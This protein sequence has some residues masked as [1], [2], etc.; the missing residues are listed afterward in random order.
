M[1][2]SSH[3]QHSS[4]GETPAPAATTA[5]AGQHVAGLWGRRG[6]DSS[7]AH[8]QHRPCE[9]GRN[10]LEPLSLES[11]VFTRV[12]PFKNKGLLFRNDVYIFWRRQFILNWKE[13]H[14]QKA[15]GYSG[16]P[17]RGK[18]SR[19]PGGSC[20]RGHAAAGHAAAG[21]AAGAHGAAHMVL[22]AAGPTMSPHKQVTSQLRREAVK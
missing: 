3:G 5:L 10:S 8:G 21:H 14:T 15:H 7:P 1:S 4:E 19:Q 13:K 20:A 2:P 17:V 12:I 11:H 22:K 16:E 6:G 18:A 9:R